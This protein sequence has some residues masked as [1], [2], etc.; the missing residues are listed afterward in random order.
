MSRSK[1][2]VGSSSKTSARRTNA[3]DVRR[4]INWILNGSIFHGVRVHGNVS[5]APLALVR[6]AVFWV[7]N[8]DDS[9]VAAAK[10]AIKKVVTLFGDAAVGSYQG[11][12]GALKRYSD[13]L[14]PRLW[15]RM[16]GLMEQCDEDSWRVGLWLALAIDGSRFNAPRTKKN[17]RAFCQRKKKAKK[18]KRKASKTGRKKKHYDPQPVGPQLW[19]TLIWHIGLQLPWSWKIG[20]SYSSERGHVLEMLDEQ[21]FPENTLFCGDAGFVGYDFLRTIAELG[22]HF[23]VRVGSNVRLL[24][25]LG[26]AREKNGLVYCWPEA[27]MKK[28]QP[29]LVWRLLHF[30]GSRGDVYLVTNVGDSRKLTPAQAKELYRRRWGI[31][32]EF[33]NIKQTYQRSKLRGRTPDVAE[34]ELH[35]SLVGISMMQ[36]LALREQSKLEKPPSSTSVATVLRVIRSIIHGLQETPAPQQSLQRQLAEATVDTYQRKSKK[37]S[38]NYPRRKE[39][40]ST[41]RPQI[42]VAS[43][44]HKQK[45]RQIPDL[46]HAY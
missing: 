29:P 28:K 31:E 43:K 22:H 1:D 33:R 17:E 24:K 14:L 37:K 3:D 7:W 6:L 35:W 40:P 16:H 5:W 2:S 34:I 42:V 15:G 38:R 41:G 46:E 45:L 8:D 20:P 18:R 11:L 21:D 44:L 25:K 19:L 39:E 27:A 10:N 26:Y 32:V 30:K 12:I 36:L 4:A 9:L 13:Q 23:L